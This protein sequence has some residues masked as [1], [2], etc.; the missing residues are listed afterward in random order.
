[1]SIIWDK[2]KNDKLRKERGVYLDAYEQSIEDAA[3]DFKP[4]SSAK[5][6]AIQALIVSANKAKNINIKISER[7]LETIKQKSVEEGLP[8]QTLISNIYTNMHIIS[9]VFGGNCGF[10][11]KKSKKNKK[12]H[13]FP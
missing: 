10:S 12:N 13:L 8:Y 9:R 3:A 4:V 6:K 7:D 11:P 2:E 1:M 5:K